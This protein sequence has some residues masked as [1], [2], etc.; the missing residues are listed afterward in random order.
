MFL[1]ELVANLLPV[2]TYFQA[3]GLTKTHQ[4]P[5]NYTSLYSGKSIR[6]APHPCAFPLRVRAHTCSHHPRTKLL[7]N[8]SAQV[9]SLCGCCHKRVI[10]K[11]FLESDSRE[12]LRMNHRIRHD[13]IVIVLETF[14]FEGSFYVVLERMAICLLQ[15]VAFPPHPGEQELITMLGEIDQV[16]MKS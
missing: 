12:E 15:I 14:R 6:L 3:R 2:F 7:E 4:W 8:L 10:V 9:R 13:H 11:S 16:D 1:R 5:S